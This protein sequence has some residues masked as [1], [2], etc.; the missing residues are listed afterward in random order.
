MQDH[1]ADPA[2]SLPIDIT[3]SKLADWLVDR[4]KIPTD[5]RKRLA[6]VQSRVRTVL[7]TLP[8]DVDSW[9]RTLDA[10]GVGYVEAKRI[11]DILLAASP[12]S[13]NFLGRATGAA[14]E[15][16]S[17][18]SAYEKD[19]LYLGEAAQLMVQN[20]NYDIPDLKR[21][22]VRLQQLVA[23]SERKEAEV[24]RSAGQ[25][26]VKYQQACQELGIEGLNI[27]AELLSL[28]K[29]LPTIFADVVEALCSGTV[30][31]ALD[32]YQAFTKYALAGEHDDTA[33]LTT[34]KELRDNPPDINAAVTL[35]PNVTEQI[36]PKE[37]RESVTQ[38]DL[39]TTEIDWGIDTTSG[40]DTGPPLDIN[41]DIGA[42]EPHSYAASKDGKVENAAEAGTPVDIDW[43]IGTIEPDLEGAGNGEGVLSS[44]Q[45]LAGASVDNPQGV[46]EISWD[47]QVP[48]GGATEINWDID[49]EEDG[50]VATTEVVSSSNFGVSYGGSELDSSGGEEV[51]Q[52]FSLAATDYRNKLLDDLFELK[53]FLKQR[54]EEMENE[55]TAALQNQVQAV[56]PTS[57]SQHGSESLMAM[58]T[59]VCQ[60]LNLLTNRKTRDL[61]LLSTS[62]RYL[63]RLETS[64]VQK[65]QNEAKLHQTMKDLI[66]KRLEL[67]NNLTMMWPKQ[68]AVVERTKSY[69][70]LVEKSVS[71]Q[72]SDRKVN[73]IG[74]INTA[75]GIF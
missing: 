56:A 29:T 73:I 61:I 74:E 31:R 39:F 33:V 44:E 36:K 48:E 58:V 42:M 19:F 23:D 3:Y 34:L 49:V 69:K 65:K 24:K 59:S 43:D 20:T 10:E 35:S 66:N 70:Q 53:A 13:R 12:D 1:G 25:S 51:K 72:Y 4:R 57:I 6:G 22:V 8:R 54:L 55:D 71:A 17:I 11:R 21:Q 41:W 45:V 7:S 75:L 50:L 40:T 62:L 27:R 14:G 68:E 67:R 38:P 32:Y 60:V 63:E 28:G 16:N 52:T 47:I 64:L 26:A 9:F 30:E 46:S 2:L 18:V 37:N 15:W 5:W